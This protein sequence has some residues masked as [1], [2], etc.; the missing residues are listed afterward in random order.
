MGEDDIVVMQENQCD[1]DDCARNMESMD[2]EGLSG[3]NSLD[4]EHGLRQWKRADGFWLDGLHA[5][6][7]W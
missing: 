7:L 2:V 1:S 5:L 3:K 4:K 6:P